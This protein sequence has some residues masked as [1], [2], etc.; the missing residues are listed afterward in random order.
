MM[1]NLYLSGDHP[2]PVD[3]SFIFAYFAVASSKG[4]VLCNFDAASANT[5]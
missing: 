4:E 5:F 2:E 1:G 3:M